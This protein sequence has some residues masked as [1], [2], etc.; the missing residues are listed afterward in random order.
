MPDFGLSA[1]NLQL[2]RHQ[3][4]SRVSPFPQAVVPGLYAF[5]EGSLDKNT[6]KEYKDRAKIQAALL[7]AGDPGNAAAPTGCSAMCMTR[8]SAS[9]CRPSFARTRTALSTSATWAW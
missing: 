5:D 8:T 9:W 7:G 3:M 4:L 1:H 2:I 6:I